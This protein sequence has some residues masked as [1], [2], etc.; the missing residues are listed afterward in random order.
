MKKDVIAIELDDYTAKLIQAQTVSSGWK[1]KNLAVE[2]ITG[3]S[4]GDVSR[5]VKDALHKFKARHY[6]VILLIPRSAVTVKYLQLPTVDPDELARMVDIQ[7]VRQIPYTRKEMVYDYKILGVA[8]NGYT[9]I[10]LVIVHRDVVLK[11]LKILK[12][13]GVEPVSINLD[14]LAM[15]QSY[16][17]I[18]TAQ[19]NK[20][21]ILADTPAAVIDI[22]YASTNIAVIQKGE[23]LVF[24]RSI[25]IGRMHLNAKTA[26]HPE[27]DWAGEWINEA[28]RSLLAYQREAG[29]ELKNILFIGLPKGRIS[30]VISEK[31]G[32]DVLFWDINSYIDG[33]SNVKE[34]LNVNGVPVSVFALL[35]SV[36]EWPSATVNLIP[37]SV[38][39]VRESKGKKRALIL[40][41][42]LSAGIIAALCLTVNKKLQDR[43][44]Y[45]RYLTKRLDDT[46]PLAK[47]LAVKKKRLVLIKKQLSVKGTSLDV[48]KELY[49]VLPEKTA[50]NVFI[51]DDKLGVTIKGIAP[52]MSDVFS[53]IPKLENLP[54][55]E[56]VRSR[57][58]TQRKIKGQELTDFDIDCSIS[59][60]S[61]GEDK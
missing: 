3:F 30:S 6:P 43:R 28:S 52:T 41:G 40:T 11:Y 44:A 23:L 42:L 49:T 25:S 13:A 22:G 50:L 18:N 33:P 14:S 12:G 24:T 9:N 58:A 1:I 21:G 55:F 37:D 45:L 59:K 10:F 61:A 5:V 46:G 34:L 39:K 35:G 48:L 27:K 36:K 7:V 54:L 31:L 20:I 56:N 26:E 57:Y 16:S 2:P 38:K 15:A 51:Y 53:L 17:F 19:V 8:D 4:E 47:E 32:A 60:M 29:V